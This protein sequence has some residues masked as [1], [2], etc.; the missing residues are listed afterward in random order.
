MCVCVHSFGFSQQNSVFLQQLE[1]KLAE[2]L[3]E[4]HIGVLLFTFLSVLKCKMN[5]I[6]ERTN[7]SSKVKTKRLQ[8]RR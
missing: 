8:H 2:D 3:Q 5:T 7:K 6:P 4:S 1:T